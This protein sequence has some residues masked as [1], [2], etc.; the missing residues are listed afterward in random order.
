MDI[1]LFLGYGTKKETL[2]KKPIYKYLSKY[3]NVII[4][5]IDYSLSIEQN[6]DNLSLNKNK[7]IFVAHSIGA[8]FIYK[9]MLT[10]PEKII[11]SIIFDGASTIKNYFVK[12]LQPKSDYEL[13]HRYS[14]DFYNMK[15]IPKPL[16]FIR[17]IDTNNEDLWYKSSIQEAEKFEKN[18]P[19][20]FNIFYVK[21]L[22]HNFYMTQKGFKAIKDILNLIFIVY[23]GNNKYNNHKLY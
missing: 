23:V 16:F 15:K 2:K 1:V 14:K 3:G 17:N 11:L 22:G 8:Y 20:T 12:E 5:D 9:L 7:Y 19:E 18:N 6:L 4:P 21:N 10:N 13:L